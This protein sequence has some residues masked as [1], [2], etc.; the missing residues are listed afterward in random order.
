MN[1]L[2]FLVRQEVHF[3]DQ[4]NKGFEA[5][6]ETCKAID[7]Y[8]IVRSLQQRSTKAQLTFMYR[9]LSSLNPEML[10]TM[11]KYAFYI[12][13][14]NEQYG[15]DRNVQTRR[16]DADSAPLPHAGLRS[17]GLVH[18]EGGLSIRPTDQVLPPSDNQS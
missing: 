9:Y 7:F 15:P 16:G 1:L 6:V 8:S 2:R 18:R 12:N 17:N 4:G 5:E 3:P 14:H 11:G 13:R 10:A